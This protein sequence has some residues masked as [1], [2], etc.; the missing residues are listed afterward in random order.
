[1]ALSQVV[2]WAVYLLTYHRT[3][4]GYLLLMLF[5]GI[6]FYLVSPFTGEWGWGHLTLVAHLA[7]NLIPAVV[8]LLAWHFFSDNSRVP[9]LFYLV[10]SIYLLLVETP[11]NLQAALVPAESYRQLVFFFLPQ[12]IKLGLVLHVIYLALSNRREDLVEQRLRMRVPFAILFAVVVSAVIVTEMGFS[13]AV[14]RS[15]EIFGA[16]VYL[17]LTLLGTTLAMRL[18]PELAALVEMTSSPGPTPAEAI[19][20]PVIADIRRLMDE[21][22]FYANYDVTVDVMAQKLNLPAYRLRPIIN[23]QMG[24][25]NFNQF[26]NS[27]RINEASERLLTQ[28]E[29]PILS[30]AL[31][32]G[33]KSLSAFNK[34]FKD[35]HGR[36]PSEFRRQN[37]A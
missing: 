37:P 18:R 3:R 2:G 7:G 30:I 12:G 29:L 10:A 16:A 9:P 33:F 8:W 26:L 36:T 19:E 11:G 25:R 15:V 24:F 34:A 27:F 17:L 31:D 14:P 1:M 21:E 35:T 23:Q 20:N 6:G 13:D 4:V 5:T 28:P 22:R 32:T